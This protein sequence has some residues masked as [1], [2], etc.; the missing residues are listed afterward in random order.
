MAVKDAVISTPEWMLERLYIAEYERVLLVKRGSNIFAKYEGNDPLLFRESNHWLL[1][2]VG[3]HML[4]HQFVLLYEDFP[5]E[6]LPTLLRQP[7]TTSQFFEIAEGLVNACIALHQQG[8]LF[9]Q[10]NPSHIFIHPMSLQ[11]KLL[12]SDDLSKWGTVVNMEQSLQH[13]LYIAPEQTGRMSLDIDA[14]ADLYALGVVFYRLLVGD[15]FRASTK[16][17]LLFQIVTK[18]PDLSAVSKKTGLVLLEQLIAKLLEKNPADRYQNALSLKQDLQLLQEGKLA[19]L[20]SGEEVFQPKPSPDICGRKDEFDVLLRSFKQVVQ[21][22]NKALFIE[23]TSGSGK[24]S[25]VYQLKPY[26]AEVD[27][28]FAE[29]KFDERQQQWIDLFIEPLRQ[30]LKQ[31]YFKGRESV[32]SFRKSIVQSNFMAKELLVKLLPELRVL[33]PNDMPI[34][35]DDV[36]FTMQQNTYLFS[37]IG[38][39]IDAIVAQGHP[40]VWF[41]DDLQW[42]DA[43]SLDILERIFT[44]HENGYLFVVTAARDEASPIVD[45]CLGWLQT[46]PYFT[47]IN[48]RLLHGAEIQEWLNKS[49][50]LSP[51]DSTHV[52]KQLF[53]YTRGNPLFMREVFLAMLKGRAIYFDV[54][55]E[56]WKI[57]DD[58]FQPIAARQDIIDF[59][60]GRMDELSPS[61]RHA[62]QLAACIGHKFSLQLLQN[63]ANIAELELLSNVEELVDQGFLIGKRQQNQ[64]LFQ[65]VHD[66]IQQAAYETITQAERQQFHYKI[67]KLLIEN[68]VKSRLMAAVDQFNL[69]MPLLNRQEREQ[70]AMWNYELALQTKKSGMFE[71]ALH[72]FLASK[73]LLPENHWHVFRELSLPIYTFIGECA[74][75]AGDYEQSQLHMKEALEHAQTSLEKLTIYRLMTFLYFEEENGEEVLEVGYLALEECGIHLPAKLQKWHVLQEY[76]RL[77]LDLRNKT[78]AQLASLPPMEKEEIDILLQIIVNLISSSFRMDANLSGVLLL[79]SVRLLLKYGSIAESAV[80]FIN[81]ALVLSAGFQDIKQALRFGKLA[82]ELAEKQENPYIKTRV[83]FAYGTFIHYWDKDYDASIKY[84]RLAQRYARQ[85]GLKSIV[86]ASSCFIV[87]MQWI[88]GMPLKSIYELICYEQGQHED[89]AMILAKDYLAEFRGWTECLRDLKGQVEWH[90]PY[91]LQHEDAV[92]VMHH[93]LRL[94]MSYY[95]A[96]EEQ[97]R[98]NLVRLDEPIRKM[99]NLVTAPFYFLYRSLWQFDW[100][101]ARPPKKIAYQYKKDIQKSINRFKKWAKITPQNFEHLLMLLQ[102]E[103]YRLKGADAEA[104]LYYDRALQL[105][106]VHQ[107]T[108][109]VALIYERAAKFY[110]S[111]HDRMKAKKYITQGI[112]VMQEWGAYKVGRL[113]DERYET[114]IAL[115]APMQEASMSFDLKTVLETTQSLAKE[116]RMEDL[117]Q[118]LLFS[119]LKHANATAGYF[120]H[121]HQGQLQLAAKVEAEDMEFSYYPEGHML[122]GSVQMVAEFVLQCDEP[123]LIPNVMKSALFTHNRS[124]A[125]SIL[126]LPVHHKGEVMAVLYLE[127]VLLY[128]AFSTIQLELI[129]MVT[130][131]IAVSIENAKIYADLEVRVA[132][133]TKQYEEM[134]QHLIAVNERLEKNEAERKKLFQNISHELRSPITSSLGYIDVILDD[135]V[136]DPDKQKEYLGRSRERLLS[137]KSLIHDLFDLAKLE[138]GRIDYE[139]SVVGVV[140][141]YEAFVER[142]RNDVERAGLVF[143]VEGHFTHDAFVSIDMARIEQVMTNL[144]VNAVKYTD[145]GSVKMVMSA[146]NGWFYCAI[147]DSGRGIPTNDLPFIFDSYFKAS[148]TNN[149]DS[150]G[151]G[152]AICKQ[153]IE[154]HAGKIAVESTE[155]KSSTF[156]FMLPLVK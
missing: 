115:A 57:N 154:Q 135:I 78:N 100:L 58:I 74:F 130:T 85:C 77:R 28:Y 151:V 44:Q 51:E 140:E 11:V 7:I 4:D 8:L 89:Q 86:S 47:R 31:L 72:L 111:Q 124:D 117:L 20:T 35:P 88:R 48:L 22:D 70:L 69:C 90:Y 75:L 13:L 129:Q 76:A 110:A 27:G 127:N 93:I 79:R 62:L 52:T 19:Q 50:M 32:E 60:V 18:K 116:I 108:S 67:G 41:L 2:F 91:T 21:G 24:S 132:E 39:I 56:R 63:L 80:V 123:V 53:Q 114:Y 112:E 136:T 26:L 10:L 96:D 119:L 138:A 73:S 87:A 144:M 14:R 139:K 66:R 95:Y 38:K 147:T 40:I 131:Q 65:F 104:M 149:V 55:E 120:M 134:N 103:N 155:Q 61:A 34:I 25:F 109:D 92:I 82:V 46:L 68:P 121:Y 49:I 156:S 9:Q 12:P 64:Q 97:A 84:V 5:G 43:S 42:A 98:E 71:Y 15:L 54:A 45:D 133:R 102:A 30:M 16:E 17:E 122:Q 3:S 37:A 6:A 23:G 59:I 143:E 125:K 148:N 83:Y 1:Q 128:N 36:E 126:C 107:F 99:F 33:L 150:H 81:F 113:W 142:Y 137:L 94:Q 152:L 118:K 105:A 106:K 29:C 145:S 101:A 146:M 153:I 141:L